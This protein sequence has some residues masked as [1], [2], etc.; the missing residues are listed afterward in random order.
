MGSCGIIL[1]VVA[2]GFVVLLPFAL[3]AAAVQEANLERLRDVYSRAKSGGQADQVIDASRAM[4]QEARLNKAKLAEVANQI[5]Q[6]LLTMLRS[7]SRYKPL[8]LEIGRLA[9]GSKRKDGL[10]T[11][12]DEQAIL[13]DISA[14]T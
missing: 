8:A 5:Y 13:N 6:D 11:V 1:I 14:H 4:V 10:P 9:Y 3:K 7:D 12:Y 2:I